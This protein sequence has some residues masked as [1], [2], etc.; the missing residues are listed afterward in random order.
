MKYVWKYN[1]KHNCFVAY[2]ALTELENYMNDDWIYYERAIVKLW[3]KH[4]NEHYIGDVSQTIIKT[5][6][7]YDSFNK[8]H[9][10]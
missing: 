1:E 3:K 10:F 8:R 4:E 7:M 9:P 5:C 6:Y 2:H